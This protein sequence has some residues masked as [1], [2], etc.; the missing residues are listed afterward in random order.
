MWQLIFLFCVRA[1]CITEQQKEHGTRVT[2]R[3]T[4]MS[5]RFERQR[6]DIRQVATLVPATFVK[7][8]FQD[9]GKILLGSSSRSRSPQRDPVRSAAHAQMFCTLD[10]I[11]EAGHGRIRAERRPAL[12]LTNS[13]VRRRERWTLSVSTRSGEH[14]AQIHPSP[15]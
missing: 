9:G 5:N 6:R 4:T 2:L 8:A 12:L 11:P 10:T 13:A 15:A 3:S 7:S 14:S 1:V